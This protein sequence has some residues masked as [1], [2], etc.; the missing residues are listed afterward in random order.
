MNI[1]ILMIPMALILGIGFVSAFLWA[2]SKGQFDDLETPAHRM[3][4]DEHERN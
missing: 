2:T 4:K 1:L 3:L